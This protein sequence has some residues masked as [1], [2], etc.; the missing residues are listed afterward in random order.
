MKQD[1]YKVLYAKALDGTLTPTEKDKLIEMNKS[2]KASGI[3]KPKDRRYKLR[4]K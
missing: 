4:F 3:L 1:I 2:F